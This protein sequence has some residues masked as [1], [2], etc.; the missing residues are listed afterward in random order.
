MV[1]AAFRHRLVMTP[2][3]TTGKSKLGKKRIIAVL[4]IVITLI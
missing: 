2:G 1:Q 3:S 4:K